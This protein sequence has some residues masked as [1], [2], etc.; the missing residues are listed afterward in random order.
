MEKPYDLIV[1]DLDGTLLNNKKQVSPYTIQVLEQLRQHVHIVFATARAPRDIQHF[2]QTLSLDTP[3][4]CYNGAM[5]F[6]NKSSTPLVSFD[7]AKETANQLITE[8][9]DF[10]D[11]SNILV[12]KNDQF[13]VDCID[14]DVTKWIEMGCEPHAMGY[15]SAFF[16]ESVA[17]IMARGE[18]SSI[19]QHVQENYTDLIHTFS[20]SKKV[21]VEFLHQQAGKERALDW[22]AAHLGIPIERTIAF[23]DADND[24]LLLKRAG[25][26][27]AMGNASSDVKEIAD[28][29]TASNEE[30]GVAKLLD[31]IY[32]LN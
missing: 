22:L 1:C 20:D 16:Q 28:Y 10:K 6:C 3:S 12:E 21:W 31:Q 17:K 8:L 29:V 30:D 25:L 23:G 14:D 13:W 32:Q 4:I 2:I 11:V 9:K 24:M 5:V 18:C 7:I 27:V 15:P 19:I 26:G